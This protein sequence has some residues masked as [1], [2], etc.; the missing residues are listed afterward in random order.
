[1]A[2]SGSAGRENPT[3]VVISE[4]NTVDGCPHFERPQQL[5]FRGNH[6]D[7][8]PFAVSHKNPTT[9]PVD[10]ETIRKAFHFVVRL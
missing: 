2:R 6:F 7:L 1:M 10:N 8:M 9:F 3:E 4:S 5:A